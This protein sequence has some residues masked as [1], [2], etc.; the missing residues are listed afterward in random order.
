MD[1][2]VDFAETRP[3]SYLVHLLITPHAGNI[4][5]KDRYLSTEIAGR[6]SPV[7]LV[8]TCVSLQDDMRPPV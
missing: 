1:L 4:R 2:S 7:G 6:K 3:L 5:L 8:L